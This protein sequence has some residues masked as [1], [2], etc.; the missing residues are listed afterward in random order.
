MNKALPDKFIRKSIYDSFDGTV[1]NTK[2]INVYDSRVTEITASPEAYVLLGIQSNLIDYNKCEN[3]WLSSIT[4]E[5]VTLYTGN[6][7]PGSRLLA[8]DIL[9]ALRLDM[10]T[11]LDLTGSGLTV[12]TQE[13]FF[14]SDLVTT[15]TNGSLFRKFLRLELKIN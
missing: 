15:L 11:D 6:G 12:L 3:F 14:P 2:T 13:M 1:V 7:N 10:V 4:L 8:D 9:E 5:V